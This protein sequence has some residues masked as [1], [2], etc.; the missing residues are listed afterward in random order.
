MMIVLVSKSF[1]TLEQRTNQDRAITMLQAKGIPFEEID[2][3]DPACK[4][5]RNELFGISGVRGK[6]P[7]FF[8]KSSEETTYVGDFEAIQ[9]M[10]E[11]GTL[12]AEFTKDTN[13][14]EVPI[15]KRPS[16]I[17]RFMSSE[18]A[19]IPNERFE[20]EFDP[21]NEPNLIPTE[22]IEN[23]PQSAGLEGQSPRN[24]E[25]PEKDM[26]KDIPKH[27]SVD[28]NIAIGILAVS[29]C[30]GIWFASRH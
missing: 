11:A 20:N 14:R 7:Q 1:G 21:D 12:G 18:S 29:V 17:S 27:T 5:R 2:G 19:I 22:T 30:L 3:G 25:I 8:I 26:D 23:E 16:S 28:L 9:Q 6:Y 13:S 15:P 4:D 10:N 24:R